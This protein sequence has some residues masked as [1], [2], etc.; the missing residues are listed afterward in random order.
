MSDK[1]LYGFD[2]TAAIPQNV[3]PAYLVCNGVD[4]LPVV[5]CRDCRYWRPDTRPEGSLDERADGLWGIGNLC[6]KHLP[7][8]QLEA[9]EFNPDDY[10][11][12]GKR[13]EHE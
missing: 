6:I 12:Y 11:K 3:Q 2:I 8:D 9:I 4:Y 5:H 7:S 10:C 1:V 13:K